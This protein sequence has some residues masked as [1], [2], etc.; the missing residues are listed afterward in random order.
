VDIRR[1]LLED[2]FLASPSEED[3]RILPRSLDLSQG[4]A[5]GSCGDDLPSAVFQMPRTRVFISTCSLSFQLQL[6]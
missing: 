4:R 6:F 5:G 3:Q 2:L 1:S